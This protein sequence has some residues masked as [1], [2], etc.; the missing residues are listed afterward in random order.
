[1]APGT[2]SPPSRESDRG[3]ARSARRGAPPAYALPESA[4]RERGDRNPTEPTRGRQPDAIRAHPLCREAF[5]AIPGRFERPRRLRTRCCPGRLFV[6][7]PRRAYATNRSP[8][9]GT[10]GSLSQ[11][12]TSR[13]RTGKAV[14]YVVESRAMRRREV[15]ESPMT[16]KRA[17]P[18]HFHPRS[19][20]RSAARRVFRSSVWSICWLSGT[21]DLTSTTSTIP[22]GG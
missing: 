12:R 16:S 7:L 4:I 3:A 8:E 13:P 2:A 5:E 1:M 22:V 11:R 10:R 19:V 15:A 9:M 17:T 20:A 21:T 14:A 18:R 6:T